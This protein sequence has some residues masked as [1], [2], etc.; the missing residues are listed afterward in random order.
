[1]AEVRFHHISLT[2]PDPLAVERYY[3][4]YFGFV[5]ARVI[6]LGASQIVFI[7]NREMYLELFQATEAA[8][9][10]PSTNDGYNWPSVRNFSFMVDDIN[11]KVAEMGADAVVAFGPLDFNDFIPGW[12][13]VWLRDPGGHLIQI[14]EGFKDD[15]SP[16]ALPPA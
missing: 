8:P 14:T 5:R 2:C 13:S 4:K 3:S 11:A 9:I 6:Q 12:K 16:P 15:S 10:P 7:R 1:M